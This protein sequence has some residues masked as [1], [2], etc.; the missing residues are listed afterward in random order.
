MAR[1]KRESAARTGA[2]PVD[3]ARAGS[4]AASVIRC[5]PGTGQVAESQ[6]S[7]LSGS[8]F[9]QFLVI[10]PDRLAKLRERS[11]HVHPGIHDP[12]EMGAIGFLAGEDGLAPPPSG[13]R[14]PAANPGR[15]APRS[16]RFPI[17]RNVLEGGAC[18]HVP[19]RFAW[20]A[21]D[22]FA[23]REVALVIFQHLDQ[24]RP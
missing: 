16:A 2:A 6:P 20:K 7:Q 8:P 17:R 24:G 11:Y 1:P 5:E 10:I 21:Q 4:G 12:V 19:F 9:G 23:G 22:M 18:I 3:M 15:P 13:A 14:P